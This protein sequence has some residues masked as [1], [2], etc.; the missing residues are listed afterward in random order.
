MLVTWSPDAQ[1]C[2]V[3]APGFFPGAC[4]WQNRVLRSHPQDWRDREQV[5]QVTG[6]QKLTGPHR[7][8]NDRGRCCGPGGRRTVGH[9]M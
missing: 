8:F 2:V 1:Y 6:C 3:V 9:H 7:G 4:V 5:V